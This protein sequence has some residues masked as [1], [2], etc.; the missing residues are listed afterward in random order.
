MNYQEWKESFVDGGGKS[1]FDIYGQGTV[2]TV[3]TT[4]QGKKTL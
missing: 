4:E 2:K 3:R 1:G